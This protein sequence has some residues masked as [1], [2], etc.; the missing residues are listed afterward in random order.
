MRAMADTQ[1]RP[2]GPESDFKALLKRLI[3]TPKAVLDEI[4]ARRVKRKRR[5]KP[6]A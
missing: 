2:L 6:A 5:K 4:E 3:E 1:D